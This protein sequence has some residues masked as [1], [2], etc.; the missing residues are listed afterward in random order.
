MSDK[1]AL[2]VYYNGECPVCRHEIESYRRTA[3]RHDTP[4]V[5]RDAMGDPAA[6]GETGMAEDAVARR[7]HVADDTGA[8]HAGV[9]AFEVLWSTLPG[10]RWLGGILRWRPGRIAAL[11]VYEGILAPV[12]YALHKRRRRRSSR[13][14]DQRPL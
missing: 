3:E 11:A 13:H 10:F 7:L 14:A 1:P 9:D 12:L 8:L 6:L 5:W 4:I 2:T